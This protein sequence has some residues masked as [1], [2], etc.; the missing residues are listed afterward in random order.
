[1]VFLQAVEELS[2]LQGGLVA[3]PDFLILSGQLKQ[4][5][6]HRPPVGFAQIR[7]RLEDFRRAHTQR[8][9][10]SAGLGKPQRGLF[11]WIPLMRRGLAVRWNQFPS[12]P[13]DP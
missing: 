10:V 5:L 1:M 12:S 11:T 13:T 9:L 7:Q 6:A 3:K 4:F 2:T 8:I